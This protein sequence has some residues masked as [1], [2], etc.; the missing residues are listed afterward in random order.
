MQTTSALNIPQSG[1]AKSRYAVALADVISGLQAT[2]IWGRL[3]W[4]DNKRR[5]RRTVFGP[6]WTT[7]SLGVFVIA[8]GLVWSNL[9]HTDPKLY[10]PF[11]TSGMLC[12]VLFSSICNEG[13]GGLISGEALIKQL[14]ISYTLLACATVWRNVIVF[15][16]NLSIYAL[17]CIYAGVSVTWA[18]L[19]TIPGLLLLCLNGLWVA[20][21]LGAVCARYRDVQQLVGSILQISLFLTP[22][23]WSADQLT[24]HASMLAEYNPLYHLIA[25]VREPL[26]GKAPETLHWL[27]VIVGTV[28]GWTLTILVLGKF[29]H[30]VV[31]WL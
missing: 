17:I 24:G 2:A 31:Y 6:L 26:M 12:W 13:C 20:V 7:V 29:R 11:L 9:W 16:H 4:R 28:F 23:F 8:L 15:F 21:L 18:T 27:V 10:L 22:I 19:L 3:G 1:P 5:Y 14:R 25:I 30:R